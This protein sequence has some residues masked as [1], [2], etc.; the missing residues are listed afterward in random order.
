NPAGR[1]GVEPGPSERPG[2]EVTVVRRCLPIKDPD[3]G[4]QPVRSPLRS[5]FRCVARRLALALGAGTTGDEATEASR[6]SKRT[7]RSNRVL[8]YGSSRR[9]TV[10]PELEAECANSPGPTTTP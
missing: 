9:E 10:T 4:H 1:G 6:S 3:P 8:Q 7:A 2:N 5:P